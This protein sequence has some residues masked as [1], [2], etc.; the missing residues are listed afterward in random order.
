MRALELL[1]K[2]RKEP[3]FGP[4]LLRSFGI[5]YAN[6]YLHRLAKQ[7]LIKRIERDAYTVYSDPFLIASRIVWPSYLSCWA[8]LAFYHLTEQVPFSLCVVAPYY[9]KQIVFERTPITFISSQQKFFFGYGKVKYQGFEIFIA[10]KEKALIDGALFKKV[11]FS[12]LRDIL[13]GHMREMDIRKFQHYLKR[14]E[15][16]SLIKRFGWL[17]DSLGK[18]IHAGLKKY[19]GNV[20]IPLDY[21]KK[22]TGTKNKKW[23]VIENA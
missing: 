13:A 10:D 8:A 18:D 9:K 17:F 2:M 4:K 20:Y 22:K 5:T 11:S 3:V 19:I 14:T 6:L 15:N 7:G 1:E 21:A 16:K 23:M 12:E